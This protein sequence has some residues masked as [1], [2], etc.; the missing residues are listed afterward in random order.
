[1][2][3]E[4]NFGICET[5]DRRFA[6]YPIHNGF[7]DSAYAYCDTCGGTCLLDLWRLPPNI[8]IKDYGVIPESVEPLLQSCDCGGSYKRGA[9]PRC[10]HCNSTLSSVA[11]TTYIEANAPGTKSGWRWQQTWDGLYCIVIEGK[12]TNDCWKT[13][14]P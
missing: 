9:P 2:A 13:A 14:A 11:A 8:E 6:Y 5:C 3:R 10:P 12:L 1:M 4:T 7:N